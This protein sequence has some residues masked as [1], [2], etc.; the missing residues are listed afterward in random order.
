MRRWIS[1]VIA[2]LA[3]ATAGARLALAAD[4][5][6]TLP[7]GTTL[8][9]RLNMTLS[10]R[11]SQT[12]DPFSGRI[13]E[14]IIQE[15]VEV[16]PNGSLVEGRVAMVKQPG[17]VKGVG[18]MRLVPESIT[19]PDEVKYTI[20]AGLEAAEGAEGAKVKDEEGT[21]KGPASKKGDVIA[22]GAGAG[23]GA[24]VGGIA[25]GGQG[26]LY[27]A[28]IGA[29][30]MGIRSLFKRGKDMVLPAGTEMTFVMNRAATAKKVASQTEPPA[31]PQSAPQ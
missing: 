14:P 11:T 29:A 22:A 15:G 31:Q 24:A 8:H 26:A 12:G 6:F 28:A 3:I 27:G 21:I 30:A 25:A 16:V 1:A 13:I 17:K 20:S 9:V 4:E 18:E 2:S 5:T 10:T 19:T 23:A 7:A